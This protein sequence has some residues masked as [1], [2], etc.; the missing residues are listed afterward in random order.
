[1]PS[2]PI[3]DPYDKTPTVSRERGVGHNVFI[4]S[5]WLTL[6]CFVIAVPSVG[7]GGGGGVDVINSGII[8]LHYK[9][10]SFVEMG[11]GV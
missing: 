3:R 8:P 1:M 11:I 5:R 9:D 6:C 2:A 4:H 10:P 7:W